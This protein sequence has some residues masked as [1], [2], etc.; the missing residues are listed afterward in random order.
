MQRPVAPRRAPDRTTPRRPGSLPTLPG[1][2][3][4]LLFLGL[5]LAL[6]T[7]LAAGCAGAGT[8]TQG[9]GRG[10]GTEPPG[11]RELVVYSG[12]KDALIQPVLEAFESETGI[13]VVLRSGGASE[14]ASAILEERSRPRADVFIANDA[15]TLENL[16]REGV[17]EPYL[18]ERVRAVPEDL[19][20]ADGSWVGVSARVRVIMYNTTLLAPEELPRTVADLADPRYRG[21]VAMAQ[22]SNESVIGHVSAL[23]HLKGDAYAEQF[24]RDLLANQVIRLKGHTQVRQAV[25]KGEFK[26]GWVNHYYYF[27]ER[28]D[29]SPVG[30]IWPDQ[31]PDDPGAVFNVA[32]VGIVKGGPNPEA[33]RAF[34]DFLLTPAAQELFARLN[35][36][37]PTLPGVPTAEGVPDLGSLKRA[38]VP[39]EVL[40]RELHRTV[41]LLEKVGF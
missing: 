37:I 15:G 8:G 1:G 29:G 25:G 36:E 26:L 41:D 24:L 10:P 39:L 33:A 18:S 30:V 38:P 14:L 13:R 17:L 16:R 31:G 34:V 3:G 23:R 12:R 22:S 9:S 11:R 7:A 5:S 6:A 21:Q 27:L 2:P 20:A 32:G 28:A 35:M 40:G 4:L 19:R